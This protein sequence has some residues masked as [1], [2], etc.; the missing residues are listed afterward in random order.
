MTKLTDKSIYYECQKCNK[1]VFYLYAPPVIGETLSASSC[2]INN[3]PIVAGTPIVCQYCR[4]SVGIGMTLY[5][6]HVKYAENTEG[7]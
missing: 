5:T 6:K 3:G 4:Q 2:Y 1:P 7:V